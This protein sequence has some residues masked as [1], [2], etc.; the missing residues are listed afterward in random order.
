[1]LNPIGSS[2]PT[3]TFIIH[4]EVQDCL[5]LKMKVLHPSEHQE[6]LNPTVKHH[7]SQLNLQQHCSHNSEPQLKDKHYIKRKPGHRAQI[8]NYV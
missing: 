2:N 4:K 7:T 5:T 6:G 8:R 3:K 1:M